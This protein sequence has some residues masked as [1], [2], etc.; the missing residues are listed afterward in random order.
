MLRFL[1]LNYL[2]VI[3]REERFSV[4]CK[5]LFKQGFSEVAVRQASARPARKSLANIK[6]K[7]SLARRVELKNNCR[8]ARITI[9]MLKQ[10]LLTSA[11][12]SLKNGQ[13]AQNEYKQV[14]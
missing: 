6:K 3:I 4:Q 5:L 14:Q 2:Q 11:T 12:A 13:Y 7:D 9:A 10:G 1:F 8:V